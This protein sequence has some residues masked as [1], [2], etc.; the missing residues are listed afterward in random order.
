MKPVLPAIRRRILLTTDVRAWYAMA[1]FAAIATVSTGFP[2]AGIAD[3]RPGTLILVGDVL[4]F[5]Q[6]NVWNRITGSAADVV[7]IA[8]ASD[9]PKLYGDFA[10]R[11]LER[12]GAFAELL[13]LAA[14]PA[15]FGLDPQRVVTDPAMVEKVRDASG[16]FFVGGAPQRLAEVLYDTDGSPSPMARAVADAHSNGAVVA[17]GIPGATGLATGIDA[18]EALARGRVSPTALFRGLGFLPSGWFVDQHAF[19]PGR[20]AEIVVAMRQLGLARGIGVGPD[21]SAVIDDGHV[22]VVGDEGVLLIDLGEDRAAR[23]FPDGFRLEGARLSYLEQGDRFDMSTL[24]VT[25]DAEKLDGFEIEHQEEEGGASDG[26]RPVAV[27]LFA[28]GRLVRLLSEALEGT[29]REAFAYAF[30]DDAGDDAQGFRFRFYSVPGTAGW[31]S[32]DSGMERYTIV[33]LGLE[34]AGARRGDTPEP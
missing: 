24:Q 12:R 25:P 27:D 29:R 6:G 23:D 9:R 13:P 22:E 17:G 32:V 2:R 8:A 28:R 5:N 20:L 3:G 15:E 34:V 31:S 10:R 1:L 11:A 16:V 19:S 4:P 18:Y 7:V 21:T 14:D 30:P 33:N 26:D